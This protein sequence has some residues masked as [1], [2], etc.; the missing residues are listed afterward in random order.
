MSVRALARIGRDG[1]IVFVAF[2][3]MALPWE[4]VVLLLLKLSRFLDELTFYYAAS[5]MVS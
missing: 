4:A 2:G 1:K 3:A 5:P